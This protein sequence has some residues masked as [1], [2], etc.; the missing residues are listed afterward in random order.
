M[1]KSTRV[2]IVADRSASMTGAKA[3]MQKKLVWDAITQYA[4]EEREGHGQY[5]VVIYGVGSTVQAA[6]RSRALHFTKPRVFEAV[7]AMNA[8]TALR[9]G[10]KA[11]IDELHRSPYEATLISVFSDGEENNSRIGAHVLASELGVVLRRSDVTFTFAGP[12]EASRYLLALGV[13]EG[14][15][16]AWD[17]SEAAMPEV[18]RETAAATTLYT[19]ARRKGVTR[20]ATLY[21]DASKLTAGGVRGMTKAV[22]P[23]EVRTVSRHMDGRAIADFFKQFEKGKHYYQLVKSEYIDEGKDLVVHIKD[24][25]EYRQGSRTVRM[26]LGLPENG[27]I[28]VAPGPHS[29]QFD[30]YVQSSSVNRKLVEGQKLLSL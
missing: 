26:L 15:F 20:S 6:V 8:N 28:R 12:A 19:E 23:S 21:A 16:K 2:I 1:S 30:I 13:P 27:R 17:G 22:T 29:E 4:S 10:I 18:V 24:K 25:N 9:D 7:G 11:A 5:D 14:N 3:E